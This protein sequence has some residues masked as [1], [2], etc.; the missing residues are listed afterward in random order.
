[1]EKFVNKL[2]IKIEF[3]LAYWPWSNRIVERNYY[4]ANV[5][6]RKTTEKDINITLQEAG[7]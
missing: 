2:G 4:S 1:M 5:I 6:V 3:S 7:N